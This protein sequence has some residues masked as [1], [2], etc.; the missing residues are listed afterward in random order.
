MTDNILSLAKNTNHAF[1]PICTTAISWLN[2]ATVVLV[3]DETEGSLKLFLAVSKVLY[4]AKRL[5]RILWQIWQ[6]SHHSPIFYPG[7]LN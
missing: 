5:W 4:S 7:P 2:V 1:C 6:S 3:I